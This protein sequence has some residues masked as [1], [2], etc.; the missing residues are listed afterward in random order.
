MDLRKPSSHEAFKELLREA[1]VLVMA[2]GRTRWP[3]S[4]LI[5]IN[6]IKFVRVWST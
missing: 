5:Q 4:G 3:A 6:V 1:D 2:T